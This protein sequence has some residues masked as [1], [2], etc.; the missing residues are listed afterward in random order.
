MELYRAK[1]VTLVTLQEAMRDGFYWSDV[2]PRLRPGPA[3][4]NRR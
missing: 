1:G 3:R 4:S 2:D